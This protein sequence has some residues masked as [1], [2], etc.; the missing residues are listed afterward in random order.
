MND[1]TSTA[2]AQTANTFK[3]LTTFSGKNDDV[4]Q[5]FNSNNISSHFVQNTDI[6]C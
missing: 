5:L 4:E 3:S 2:Q 1:M 6:K